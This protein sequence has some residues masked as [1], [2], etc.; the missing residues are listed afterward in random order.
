MTL[1][2]AACLSLITQT[3]T[4]CGGKVKHAAASFSRFGH[5]SALI[6][7]VVSEAKIH[8]CEGSSFNTAV[9]IT[10]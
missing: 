8:N 2:A 3:L 9:F 4:V 5:L 7:G 6:K 1:S 10:V